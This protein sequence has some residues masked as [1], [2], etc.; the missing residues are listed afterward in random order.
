MNGQELPNQLEFSLF[1]IGRKCR[2]TLIPSSS[3]VFHHVPCRFQLDFGAVVLVVL[4]QK[5]AM[6]KLK[7]VFQEL[8]GS[9]IFFLPNHQ[10]TVGKKT[11]KKPATNPLI[12]NLHCPTRQGTHSTP[13]DH[14]FASALTVEK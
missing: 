9:T 7:L 8:T 11:Q 1:L 3:T 2:D 14:R 13:T 10:K 5:K 12:V 4:L 6:N